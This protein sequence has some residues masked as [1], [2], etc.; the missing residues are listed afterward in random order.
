MEDERVKVAKACEMATGRYV[1]GGKA[2]TTDYSSHSQHRE[3][4]DVPEVIS[5]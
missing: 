1:F 4:K 2:I 3:K 5:Y